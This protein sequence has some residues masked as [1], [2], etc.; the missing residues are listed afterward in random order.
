ML[1]FFLPQ[2]LSHSYKGRLDKKSNIVWSYTD[3]KKCDGTQVGINDQ[4]YGADSFL[5]S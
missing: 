5:R 4:L 1:L 2:V 3:G